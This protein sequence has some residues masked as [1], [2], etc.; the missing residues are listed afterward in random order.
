MNLKTSH[1][2]ILLS[3]IFLSCFHAQQEIDYSTIYGYW[4]ISL[5]DEMGVQHFVAVF[6]DEDGEPACEFHSYQDGMK[7]GSEQS[8]DIK[9]DGK[10]ISMIANRSANVRYK[11]E[12][13]FNEK[14]I[15]GKLIYTDGSSR[16]FNLENYSKEKIQKDFPGLIDIHQLNYS[17]QIPEHAEDGWNVSSLGEMRINVE[18]IN[19]MIEVLSG[20]DFG[21][22]NSILIVRNGKLVFEEYFDGFSKNDLHELRSTTKSIASLLMGIANDKNLIESVEQKL[23][24]FFPGYKNTLAG[25][26]QNITLKHVLS[27]TIGL[28]WNDRF[29]DNIW[30]LSDDVIKSTFEQKFKSKPGEKFEYQSPQ[31]NLLASVI[32]NTTGES[33]QKFAEENL[34]KPLGIKKYLWKN[35]KHNN[36][37]LMDGSLALRP[38][39]MAKIGQMI[40]NKGSF[41]GNQVI[42]KEWIE[43]SSSFKVEADEFFDYG[44]LWWLGESHSRPGIKVIF[45]N[46]LGGQHIVIIPDLSVVIVTT[47][48]NYDKPAGLLIKMIDK[49]ILPAI[50]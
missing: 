47:G 45:S 19:E 26:W 33:V 29:H 27:M 31:I 42:S 43:E 7:F 34:F 50:N 37:P 17:Y 44:Y 40:L 14:L 15:R 28:S 24:D 35:F 8:A 3:I 5:M 4:G 22:I 18:K 12:V 32:M 16:E 46:G 36:Y 41:D 10:N 20:G 25:E 30:N 13:D 11:G 1:I 9:F 2:G 6:Y 39:D 23:L 21:E 38:R 48:E 49:Y